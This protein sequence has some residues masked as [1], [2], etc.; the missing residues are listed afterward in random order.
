L[1][2]QRA[3]RAAAWWACRWTALGRP[4]NTLAALALREATRVDGGGEGVSMG[5]V[6]AAHWA[7]PRLPRNPTRCSGVDS[8]RRRGALLALL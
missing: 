3:P 2:H 6:G 1:A 7:G 4:R 5:H 8:G